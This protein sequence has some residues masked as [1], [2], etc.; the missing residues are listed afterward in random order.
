MNN[1]IGLVSLIIVFIVVI[2]A[3]YIILRKGAAHFDGI[4]AKQLMDS[5]NAHD[6]VREQ[7][8]SVLRSKY[9]QDSVKI[10]SIRSEIDKVPGLVKEINKTYDKKRS[11][12]NSLSVDEQVGHMSDWLSKDSSLGE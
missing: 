11:H 5:L 8:L 4:T 10:T 3:N 7:Q 1:K 12:V 2:F 9:E 6:K